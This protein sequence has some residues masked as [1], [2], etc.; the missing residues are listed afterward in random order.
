MNG[1]IEMGERGRQR[2]TDTMSGA[3]LGYDAQG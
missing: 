1:D 2:N 3:A